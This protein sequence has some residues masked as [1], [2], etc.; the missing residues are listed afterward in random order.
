MEMTQIRISVFSSC[1]VCRLWVP[2]WPHEWAA[3]RDFYDS[4]AA[5]V[6]GIVTSTGILDTVPRKSSCYFVSYF[7]NI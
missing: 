2:A 4:S 3:L 6:T 7:S 5:A 1:F